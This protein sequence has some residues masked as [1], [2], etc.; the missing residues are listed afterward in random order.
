MRSSRRQR[1]ARRSPAARAAARAAAS[2]CRCRAPRASGCCRSSRRCR[3]SGARRCRARFAAAE[4]A[5]EAAGLK[6][7]PR[8]QRPRALDGLLRA[9]RALPLPRGGKLLDPSRA[10]A[11]VPRISRDV[12]GRAVCRADPGRGDAGG[13]AQGVDGRARAAGRRRRLVSA[14]DAD[15][16]GADATA[17]GHAT[18]GAGVGAA[19]FARPVVSDKA[20]GRSEVSGFFLRCAGQS[21]HLNARKRIRMRLRP[22]L[23]SRLR[24]S[25]K[26]GRHCAWGYSAAPATGDRGSWSQNA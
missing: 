14:G 17:Q 19:V 22:P 4:A 26:V 18:D 12:A 9:R 10:A 23:L 5:I 20:I 25:K 21:A 7:A 11:G 15:G 6:D 16:V 3:R 24:E 13:G 2:S 1:W 8:A